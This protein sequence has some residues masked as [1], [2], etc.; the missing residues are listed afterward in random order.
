MQG[1]YH[2]HSTSNSRPRV[3]REFRPRLLIHDGP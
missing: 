3:P 2:V 1:D